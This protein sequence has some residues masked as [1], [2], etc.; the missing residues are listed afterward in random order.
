ML[1]PKPGKLPTD[2]TVPILS[3]KAIIYTGAPITIGPAGI[4]QIQLALQ[5]RGFKEVVI[6]GK[7]SEQASGALKKFQEAQKLDQTG[8]VNLRTLKALG[9]NNPL[10][11]LDQAAPAAP[12]P[13]K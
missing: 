2:S 10:A 9:F 7:W 4:K 3:D 13:T 5:Q 1:D 12:K 11:D 6:D 8:S